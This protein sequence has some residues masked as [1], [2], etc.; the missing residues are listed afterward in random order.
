M[1]NRILILCNVRQHSA[2]T[3]EAEHGAMRILKKFIRR[4]P[5]LPDTDHS[6]FALDSR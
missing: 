2:G 4:N 6:Y 5:G 1:R 3:I